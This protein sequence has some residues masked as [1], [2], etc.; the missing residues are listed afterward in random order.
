M[1]P[2][3]GTTLNLAEAPQADRQREFIRGLIDRGAGKAEI[4]QAL[5]DQY[6]PQVL[7]SP[8]RRGFAVAA[9]LVPVGL[10]IAALL[11]LALA[12]TRWRGRG[13]GPAP[14]APVL[15]EPEARRLDDE[16]AR[17]DG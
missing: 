13:A 7:A 15:A 6:G 4:K 10:G 11:G 1:C 3:C 2:V 12:V 8:P 16:L 14:A 5:V 17:F 9:Y